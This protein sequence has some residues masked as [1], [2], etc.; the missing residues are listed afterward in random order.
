MIYK[1]DI[2]AVILYGSEIW[3]VMDAMMTVL[4][5][6]TIGLQYGLLDDGTEGQ[7]WRMVVGLGR[8]GAGGDRVT[9]DEGVRV[10]AAG[11]HCGVHRGEADL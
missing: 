7:H 11:N 8:S 2:Q 1:E 6:S 5:F 3:V 9:G 4:E 10:K